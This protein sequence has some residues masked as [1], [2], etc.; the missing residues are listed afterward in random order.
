M[1][2]WYKELVYGS[3]VT[4][5]FFLP[6]FVRLYDDLLSPLKSYM[7]DIGKVPFISF[8]VG[9]FDTQRYTGE[10]TLL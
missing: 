4:F 3:N 6:K 9:L 2:F 7:M 8:S 10:Y 5:F 1:N